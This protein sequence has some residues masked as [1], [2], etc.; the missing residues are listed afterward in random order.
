MKTALSVQTAKATVDIIIVTWN[1]LNMLDRAISSIMQNT[2]EPVRII[3]VNNGDQRFD[4][5]PAS[6][7]IVLQQEKNLGWTAGVNA[8]V[9]WVLANNPAPFI[10]WLNDDIQILPH[11]FGWLTKMLNCFQLDPKIA[12]VGPTSNNIMG[13][14]TTNYVKLPPAVETTFLSG[15]CMLVR[16]EVVQEM[17]PLD[18][19]PAGGDDLDFSIRLSQAGYKICICRRSFMLHF[20]SVTGKK[21]YGEYWN[22]PAQGEAI[23]TWLIKKHGFKAWYS[24]MHHVLPKNEGEKDSFVDYENTLA[25]NEIE[26]LLGDDKLVLDLG[27]GGQK[28]HPKMVGVDIRRNGQVGVGANADKPAV[29]DMESDV[30]NLPLKD[31]TVDG[32]LAKHLLE[33]VIDPVQALTEWCRVLKAGG[34]LVVLC[35]DYRYCEAISVDPSHVHAF[36]PE[37]VASLMRVCGLQVT[38]TEQV[39]PGY[40]FMVVGQPIPTPQNHPFYVSVSGGVA[41]AA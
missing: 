8:G 30:L 11:D 41:V 24:C 35:P 31:H 2:G 37:S 6:G 13:F 20:C 16:S 26:P 1:N 5:P 40:V 39:K 29:A 25:L 23:N 10:M 32:I 14:Q 17:G 38:R 19:C 18:A 34:K 33:H 12:V 15:M 21:V 3:V 22:S 7:V 4:V 28:L 27:C 36:T 9:R